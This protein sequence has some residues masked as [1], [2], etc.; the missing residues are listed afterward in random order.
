MTT[1]HMDVEVARNVQRQLVT[2]HQTLQ[3]LL[4][5]ASSEVGKLETGAWQGPS[6]TQ[7]YSLFGEWRTRTSR[8]LEEFQQLATRL[9]SEITQWEEA[10]RALE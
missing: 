10:A 3:N 8:L 5:Q 1:L 7:F 9:Q 4:S 6:A 2:I